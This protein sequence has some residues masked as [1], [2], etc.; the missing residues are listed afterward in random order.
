MG[1]LRLAGADEANYFYPQHPNTNRVRAH[2]ARFGDTIT[3]VQAPRERTRTAADRGHPDHPR[4]GAS[5]AR[6][7]RREQWSDDR[8]GRFVV[9]GLVMA[10]A[11]L[12]V[13]AGV[14]WAGGGNR[15]S[16]AMAANASTMSPPTEPAP[17]IANS[18]PASTLPLS[19]YPLPAQGLAMTDAAKARAG[20]AGQPAPPPSR[21]P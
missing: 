6:F 16:D 9:V 12:L 2:V 17:A 19:S 11:F 5:D 18:A 20:R 10:L 8:T 3:V 1:T 4:D 13:A 21:K 14:W 7:D 15:T